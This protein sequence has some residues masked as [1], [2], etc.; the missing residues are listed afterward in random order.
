MNIYQGRLLRLF[1]PWR[2]PLC[3]CPVKYSLHPYTGCSH[4][5]L[6]CYATAYI[7]LRESTPKKNFIEN[8]R[9]E[10][11]KANRNI[12]VEMSTSSDPYP[13]IEDKLRLTRQTLKELFRRGFRVL[14]TTKSSLVTRDLDLL[15]ANRS[16]VMITITT[17]DKRLSEIIEP[18]A[19]PPSERL[20]AL[21]ELAKKGVPVGARVDPV[22]P[23][24]N[25]DPAEL[26]LLV[27]KLQ[28]VGVKH[29]VTSTYKAKPDSYRR[30]V[31]AL[32]E[33]EDKL[34]NIYFK[35]K[36]YVSGYYYLSLDVR[37]KLLRPVVN[38]A[39]K[40][41]LSYATC[42]E[43]L[44]TKEFFSARS[45]DGSHLLSYSSP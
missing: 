36:T 31:S 38:L 39:R 5:C 19:P 32:P 16:A 14:I 4:K 33:L 17:L 13:P 6:Y 15:S 27:E 18:G 1:D 43:G 41:G 26:S 42:R 25:D 21:K 34:R 37:M 7:G 45:C 40:L 9:K 30:I 35:E 24:V 12:I 20:L 11:D 3:T 10:L 44:V 8:L 22:I 2:S 23:F 29:V 28:E